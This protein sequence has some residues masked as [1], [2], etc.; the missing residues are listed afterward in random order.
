MMSTATVASEVFES[1][2]DCSYVWPMVEAAL[3]DLDGW[4]RLDRYT[5]VGPRVDGDAPWA[6]LT[7]DGCIRARGVDWVRV[8]LNARR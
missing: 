2:A 5:W 8:V 1:P 3:A 7:G 6:V 4:H